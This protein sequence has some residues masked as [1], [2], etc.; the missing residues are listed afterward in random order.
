[1]ASGNKACPPANIASIAVKWQRE[2]TL[3]CIVCVVWS[4][5]FRVILVHFRDREVE[6][7]MEHNLRKWDGNSK[8]FKRLLKAIK[9]KFKLKTKFHIFDPNDKMY[10]DDIDDLCGCYIGFESDPDFVLKLEIKVTLLSLPCS[11]QTRTSTFRCSPFLWKHCLH[12]LC[13]ISLSLSHT[14]FGLRF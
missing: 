10:V 5:L 1:M 11:L 13:A 3:Y 4:Q 12:S 14:H 7:E 6:F 8:M 2:I 9:T